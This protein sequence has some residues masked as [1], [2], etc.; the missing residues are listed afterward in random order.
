[1]SATPSDT[2][3]AGMADDLQAEYAFDY[4]QA[5]PNRFVAQP[6]ERGRTIVLDPDIAEVFTSSASVNSV[7]RALI[8]AMPNR[9]H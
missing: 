2:P 8:Q 5:R 7:L 9:A 3:D 1:M 6:A 4:R